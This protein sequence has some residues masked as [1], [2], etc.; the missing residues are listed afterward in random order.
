M[1]SIALICLAFLAVAFLYA[2]V[3]HG[4]ASGYLAVL[5]LFSLA[6]KEMSSTALILNLVV[7]GIAFIMY[8]RAGQFSMRLTFPFMIG[9]IPLAF[10]GGAMTVETSVY[11]IL[12]G[13][14]LIAAAIR[15]ILR[16]ELFSLREENYTFPPLAI[17]L[18]AGAAIGLISGLVGVGGGIFLSPLILLMRWADP[19]R[20]SAT[21]ALF[22]ILNS[23]A[24]IIGRILNGNFATGSLF[25]FLLAA[26]VGGLLGSYWGSRK[27][28]NI[29]LRRILGVALLIATMKLLI[30]AFSL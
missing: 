20:T 11:S 17:A 16:V 15:L 23:A 10:V 22:I 8:Y 3:G 24:G 9:S 26:A 6:P 14:A 5:S 28:S 19:K 21:S 13:I 7:A 25:P 18:P 2:S 29:A 4:G 12:L 30:T 27:S 1:I